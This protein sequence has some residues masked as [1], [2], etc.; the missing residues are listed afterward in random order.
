VSEFGPAVHRGGVYGTINA[1]AGHQIRE[2]R[3][4]RDAATM[5]SF[6]RFWFGDGTFANGTK[7][8]G[9]EA[10]SSWIISAAV[11]RAKVKGSLDWLHDKLEAMV[12]AVRSYCPVART[13]LRVF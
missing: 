7:K 6:V 5:D 12:R 13:R 1:A 11:E 10:Y 9:N 8:S 3:W 4:I 2:G